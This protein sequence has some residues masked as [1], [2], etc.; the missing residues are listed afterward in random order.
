MEPLPLVREK[1][2]KNPSFGSVMSCSN[3]NMNH[4]M[5]WWLFLK[6][7]NRWQCYYRDT[8]CCKRVVQLMPT[9]LLVYN[10]VRDQ[11]GRIQ[12]IFV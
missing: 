11:Q 9:L 3:R 2:V 12:D 8:V 4:T 1:G 5:K 10:V 7:N 6:D